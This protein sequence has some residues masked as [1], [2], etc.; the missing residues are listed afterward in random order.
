M[1]SGKLRSVIEKTLQNLDVSEV[2]FVVEHPTDLS[3]GDYSTN[4]AMAASKSLGKNPRV[5][6][7]MI[8]DEIK[9]EIFPEIANIEIAG[10]GF[11]NFKLVPEFFIKS[12]SEI[13]TAE[14]SF[15]NLEI[16]DGKNILIEHSSPNLF[17]PFHIGHMMNNAIGESLVRLMRA[18]GANV[19]TMSFPSDISLGVAKAVYALRY[20]LTTVNRQA[21]SSGFDYAIIAGDAYVVGTRLYEDSDDVKAKVKEIADVLYNYTSNYVGTSKDYPKDDLEKYSW[22]DLY[23]KFSNA[24]RTYLFSFLKDKLETEIDNFIFESESG[25]QGK[26]IVESYT[27]TVFTKSEGAIVYVPDE[28]RKDINTSVFI[29]SQGNP[30]YEAKDLGLIDLKFERYNPDLSIF[31]TDHEQ[32]PH[33]NVVLAAYAD[34]EKERKSL[35]EEVYNAVEKS[36]HVP[37]GRMLFK[38]QKMSSR[39]GGVPPAAEM[40]EDVALEVKKKMLHRDSNYANIDYVS[41]R[42]AIGAIKFAILRA[43]PGMNINFDPETSLSFEGDSGPYLQ[44]THA[45]IQTL[46]DKGLEQNIAAEIQIGNEV[47]DIEKLL[48]RFP[49]VVE[50]AVSE[51]A[52]NYIVTYLLEIAR[53]FNSFYGANKIIDV[54]NPET[55]SHRLAIARA[56]QIVIRNGLQLLAIEAPDRM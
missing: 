24:S 55:S 44:Y 54:E 52:P 15:G 2:S 26:E 17:K 33:F 42:I 18:S 49:E 46:L 28:S 38:G 35:K 16:N 25:V 9:K 53:S 3:H 41:E 8:V 47:S 56:T 7:E 39:L 31:V 6:A 10:P 22:T 36:E 4:I 23:L 37:H 43:K 29:N 34:L 19:T 50:S 20:D 14:H 11:I 45:R 1:I 27:S 32:I 12:I 30:T 5:V 21:D 48:Y 51:Y 40:I 13:I